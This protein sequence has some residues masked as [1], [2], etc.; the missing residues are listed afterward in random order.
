MPAET[1]SSNKSR[2]DHGNSPVFVLI[3]YDEL[4]QRPCNDAFEVEFAALETP[5][6]VVKELCLGRLPSNAVLYVSHPYSQRERV[7]DGEYRVVNK[8]HISEPVMLKNFSLSQQDD[9]GLGQ[10]NV[11]AVTDAVQAACKNSKSS[12]VFT[13]R[14]SAEKD[15][16]LK[17]VKLFTA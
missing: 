11:P 1:K 17:K 9:D 14:L 6:R 8:V 2:F 15:W 7:G 10:I 12:K 4:E 5:P 3:P 16:A 13:A